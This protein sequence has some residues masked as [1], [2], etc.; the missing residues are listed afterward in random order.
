MS[1]KSEILALTGLKQ[2]IITVRGRKLLVQEMTGAE[3]DKVS[4]ESLDAKDEFDEEKFSNNL[5]A[6]CVR[7]PKTKKRVF[8]PTDVAALRKLSWHVS[9]PIKNAVVDINGLG[10]EELKKAEK[11]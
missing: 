11:N 4:R 7:D 5:M 10:D 1:L 2:K 8:T 6:C 9:Q 3:R